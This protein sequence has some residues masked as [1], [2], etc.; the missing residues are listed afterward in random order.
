MRHGEERDYGIETEFVDARG[1]LQQVS[2]QAF[3]AVRRSLTPV[4]THP[5][6]AAPAVLRKGVSLGP[7]LREAVA[8]PVDF[9][10]YH[11]APDGLHELARARDTRWPF[12]AGQFEPGVYRLKLVDA[13]GERDEAPLIVAPQRAF[14]GAFGRVWVVAVQLYGLRSRTNWGIGDF[15]DLAALMRWAAEAG[16]AGV[17]LNPL[18]ALFDDHLTDCSPYSP[19][20]RL[21]LDP[22][23]IHVPSAPGFSA[24]LVPGLARRTASLRDADLVDYG[25]VAEL[26]WSAL[27]AAFLRFMTHGAPAER[28]EFETFR[29]EGASLLARYG[30]FEFLRRRFAA[31]WWEWPTEWRQPNDTRLEK[32]RHGEDADAIAYFEFLQWVAD[33]QL[34]RCK[35]LVAEL[36]MPVGLYIDL[37]VGVKPDGFDAW[38]NQIAITRDLSVGAPPDLLNTAGQ[39]WGLAAFSS[40]GLEAT[41][42]Q[43]FR[44]MLAAA[45]RYAGAIRIDHVLGLQRLYLVPSGASPRDGAYVRMP[46]AAL[47]ALVAI[48]SQAHRCVVVGEDL[49]TVPSGLR[50]RLAD[51]GIWCYRV[52]LFERDDDGTFLPAGRYATDA[53]VTFDTHDLPTFAGWRAGHDLRVKRGLGLDPGETD[54]ERARSL[55]KFDEVTAA[56]GD[57]PGFARAVGFLAHTPCRILALALEDLLGVKD[58]PNVPGTIDQHPNWRRKLPLSIED[59]GTELALAPFRLALAGRGQ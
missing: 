13:R 41:L 6:I 11:D 12:L 23:Y 49:G 15:G 51:H 31:P 30:C 38:N 32:L 35:D 10:V 36:K 57:L 4:P 27:R 5:L 20:S 56:T 2:L 16:A 9:A 37:A 18:H 33:R 24:D 43:P 3:E 53:L 1:Q 47:L 39:D 28:D 22:L 26:K 46:L 45:M 25:A 42:F 48:E 59:L 55:L 14:S 58:Q 7:R 8:A 52:M 44:D 34:R 17:G 21:F 54:D 40:A 29:R 19:S 50:E